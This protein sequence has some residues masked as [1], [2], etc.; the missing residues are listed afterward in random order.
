MVVS[1]LG[2]RL[3]C[4]TPS[5]EDPGYGWYTAN[6]N[7]GMAY[8]VSF[9]VLEGLD[10]LRP[11]Q[12]RDDHTLET[13]VAALDTY[14]WLPGFLA[15]F[16]QHYCLFVQLYLIPPRLDSECDLESGS[17][18]PEFGRVRNALVIVGLMACYEL[19][20][21]TI[22]IAGYLIIKKSAFHAPILG[23]V[24]EGTQIILWLTACA[25]PLSLI[26]VSYPEFG[27]VRNALVIV[28]LMA[29]YALVVPTIF[30]AGYL[31]MKKSAFHAPILGVVTERT[32][33]ILWLTAC[34]CP[35][36]LI[37]VSYQR[38]PRCAFSPVQVQILAISLL[39]IS[40]MLPLLLDDMAYENEDRWFRQNPFLIRR[41][42]ELFGLKRSE[43][44]NRNFFLLFATLSIESIM[45][46]YIYVYNPSKTYKPPWTEY[47]G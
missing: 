23:V 37:V 35:L 40:I 22:F 43:R 13:D 44:G 31:I 6:E 2:L 21:P 8:L 32:Q 11:Q 45:C 5:H 4:I 28:G 16:T 24:T 38:E 12:H 34:A 17:Y 33:I 15:V 46:Y 26:V 30:I 7:M 18:P 9:L 27:G 41:F 19:V 39:L 47:L 20:V 10:L 1:L 14:M 25:C 42:R 3:G 36:S 29:C